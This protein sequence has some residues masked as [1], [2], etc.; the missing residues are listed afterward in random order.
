[1]PKYVLD[2][3][4]KPLG[5]TPTRSEVAHCRTHGAVMKRHFRRVA[6]QFPN[7][8]ICPRHVS[9]LACLNGSG[10]LRENRQ[11]LGGQINAAR[12]DGFRTLLESARLPSHAAA[13]THRLPDICVLPYIHEA[14]EFQI[15]FCFFSHAVPI[16]LCEKMNVHSGLESGCSVAVFVVS[17]SELLGL[18]GLFQEEKLPSQLTKSIKCL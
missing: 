8:L 1:M 4:S 2:L 16:L 10:S 5:E 3:R 15:V 17:N 12:K 6:P 11:K 14:K 13:A 7:T 9:G 18:C